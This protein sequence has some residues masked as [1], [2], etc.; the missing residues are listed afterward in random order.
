MSSALALDLR[1][2]RRP[3][4]GRRVQ[5]KSGAGEEA[6]ER[7]VHALPEGFRLLDCEIVGTI[8]ENASGIVYLAWDHVLEQHVAIREYL[9]RALAS[10]ACVS[11]AVVARS[12]SHVAQ[13]RAGLRRFVDQARVLSGFDH[14]SLLR[15]LHFWAANGT[16][17]VAMPYY[18]GSTLAR[19]LV[20]LGRPPDEAHLCHWLCPLLDALG[21]VHASNFV[22]GGIAP[23]RILL[24][25]EGPVLT[26]FGGMRGVGSDSDA[27]A[28]DLREL[29]GVVYAAVTGQPRMPWDDRVRPLADV[30]HGRYSAH[31]LDAV[32]AALSPSPQDAGPSAAELWGRLSGAHERSDPDLDLL[33]ASERPAFV[34]DAT[35]GRELPPVLNG[36]LVPRRTRARTA[37]RIAVGLLVVIGAIGTLQL[38]D[39]GFSSSPPEPVPIATLASVPAPDPVSLQ[40][41][42]PVPTP[43]SASTESLP[44]EQAALE[45]AAAEPARKAPPRSRP[46]PVRERVREPQ[47]PLATVQAGT[48]RAQC[49]EFLQR[50]SLG[51]LAAGEVALLRKDCEP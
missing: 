5:A 2:V 7:D 13:F 39:Q 44:R 34:S 21:T 47:A 23:H 27:L 29:A 35:F 3:V 46:E 1:T 37:A 31:F 22:H 28:S 32:D 20:E 26:A 15:V 40:M 51:P 17:Y 50:A 10:R 8:G 19:S 42:T 11:A 25:D 12:P 30:A 38:G 9:P 24:T 6:P 43:P 48:G 14:P 49:V 18:E 4:T 45:P 41:Q 33:R 36:D 16:A